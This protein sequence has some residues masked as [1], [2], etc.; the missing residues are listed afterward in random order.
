MSRQTRLG[1]DRK[2]IKN[3]AQTAEMTR[4]KDNP[5]DEVKTWLAIQKERRKTRNSNENTQTQHYSS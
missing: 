4:H 5:L 1:R 2:I 3:Y